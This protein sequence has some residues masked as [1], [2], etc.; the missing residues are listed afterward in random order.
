M[1]KFMTYQRPSPANKNTWKGQSS[2]NPYQPVRKGKYAPAI[3][4]TTRPALP[5]TLPPGLKLP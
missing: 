4:E 2:P 5:V 3:P 1:P